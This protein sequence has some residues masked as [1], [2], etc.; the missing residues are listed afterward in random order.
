MLDLEIFKIVEMTF[1]VTKCH[2][3]RYSTDHIRLYCTVS[4]IV[5]FV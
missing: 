1:K 3:W 2:C 5:T 4:E